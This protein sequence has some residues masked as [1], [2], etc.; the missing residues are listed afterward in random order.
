MSLWG[1]YKV[2]RGIRIALLATNIRKNGRSKSYQKDFKNEI[3][4]K[5][6]FTNEFPLYFYFL[7]YFC[8]K[9]LFMHVLFF[10]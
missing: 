8:L 2:K 5:F 3:Q 1:N 10:T 4:W 7:E 6:N 9:L